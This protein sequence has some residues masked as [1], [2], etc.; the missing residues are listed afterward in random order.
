MFRDEK[1]DENQEYSS[2]TI[3][4][5]PGYSTKNHR[6]R[7]NAESPMMSDNKRLYNEVIHY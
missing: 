2:I 1:T 6:F 7:E 5:H 3:Y 4:S